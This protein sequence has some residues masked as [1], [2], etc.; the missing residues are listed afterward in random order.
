MPEYPTGTRNKENTTQEMAE[1][2]RYYTCQNCKRAFATIMGKTS[3]LEHHPKCK[4][5]PQADKFENRRQDCNRNFR[6]PSELKDHRNYIC[7]QQEAT[8]Q[9]G[10]SFYEDRTRQKAQYFPI[11]DGAEHTPKEAADQG[12]KIQEAE[13]QREKERREEATAGGTNY[14]WGNYNRGET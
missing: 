7:T 1:S 2:K 12:M 9:Q 8:E 6:N 13:R 4:E 5:V 3:H 10:E 14:T 11:Q